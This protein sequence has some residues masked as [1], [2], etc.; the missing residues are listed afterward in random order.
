MIATGMLL[1][2]LAGCSARRDSA[3]VSVA[4]SADTP[5]AAREATALDHDARTGARRSAEA[6][7]ASR[8][9]G[10]VIRA[11]GWQAPAGWSGDIDARRP[12]SPDQAGGPATWKRASALPNA[13]RLKVGDREELPL[14]A[15]QFSVRVDAFR[16]RVMMDCLYHNDT[17]RQLEGT[18]Q[19][20]LPDGASPC[21][22][23]FGN[24][25]YSAREVAAGRAGVLERNAAGQGFSP[26]EAIEVRRGSSGWDRPIEA[27]MV[28]REKAG[29]AY[30]ET[31]HRRVDPAIMEWSGAGVFSTRVYPLLP[32]RI[33]RVVV[34]Y[35][36]DLTPAG[37]D[38]ELRLDLPAG[39]ASRIVDL[40]VAA[41][42]GMR[43]TVE[44]ETRPLAAP[45]RELFRVE[46][47][48]ADAVT[49]R[50]AGAGSVLLT[51]SDAGTGQLFAASF[52][53]ELPAGEQARPCSRAVF[54]LDTSL[55]S[56]PDRCNVHLRLLESILESN[57]ES[58]RE[59]AVVTFDISPR[60][61]R[62]EWSA[63]T[64]EGRKALLAWA[65]NLSLEGATD[66]SAA[67][68][69]AASPDWLSGA[70][71]DQERDIFL[72]GDGAA[73]WG[74]TDP[75]ALAATVRGGRG[76]A[77]FAYRTGLA[78]GDGSTLENLA[79]A[80]G[81]AVF[82]VTGEA[83]IA[84]AA[85]A[86]R[87]RSWR[88][89]EVRVEG[90]SDLLL[91]GRPES[92]F[93]GQQLLLVGRG[94]P[95]EGAVC[96]LL[97]SRG[98]EQRTVRTAIARSMESPL[99]ARTY[100]QVAVG[101]LEDLL[102]A[103]ET[104]ARHYAAHFRVTGRTCSLLMLESER[105]YQRFGL[106][107]A[108][109]AAAVRKEP[110]AAA[111][112]AAAASAQDGAGSAR[113]AFMVMVARLEAA[114]G[115]KI[116]APL[117]EM[118][119]SLP[120]EAFAVETERL[121][122]R[123]LTRARQSAGY[124]KGLAA[125]EAD[126]GAVWNEAA[127]RLETLGP[128]DALRALSSLVESRP[129]DR[130]LVQDVGMSALGWNLPGHGYHLFASLTSARP[131]EA[132][133]YRA[134]ALCLHELGRADLALAC[135]EL[136]LAGQG[137]PRLGNHQRIVALDYL[138]L[139]RAVEDGRLRPNGAWFARQRLAE[140]SREHDL[141][142]LDLLVS[143]DWNTDATDVDLRVTE[144]SGE[145]CSSSR[146]GTRGGGAMSANVTDGFGPEMYTV[147]RAPA[148]NYRISA[149]YMTGDRNRGHTATRVYATIVT[150]WGTDWERV[151]HR[152]VLLDR[153]GCLRELATVRFDGRKG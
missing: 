140:L 91:A 126:S 22:L 149:R 78:G 129:G 98:G 145:T 1:A 69:E 34:G 39:V 59:F 143:M 121:M 116:S 136:A 50:L 45:G 113:A 23:A 24:T 61:W 43:V 148:G 90:G 106:V 68:R 85:L 58:L 4:R 32:H 17:G 62:R 27:R 115:A 132:Q 5:L 142:E 9:S 75:A 93:P 138:R 80:S 3:A 127:R 139:L 108:D 35:D 70:P 20:R 96:E 33:S 144:P 36:L 41:P 117:R 31:V 42:R 152:A 7:G 119:A 74:E 146:P 25:T 101:Q 133:A 26:E 72:L 29:L 28:P 84:A 38:L 109:D 53:P 105:D 15:V 77:L 12:E 10:E 83:G 2:A 48:K 102:P 66:L 21:Y 120:N 97:L 128:A 147:K 30:R 137:D 67:L 122:P 65:G 51:G 71:A 14:R 76:G 73:T 18:F 123:R 13:T 11:G 8:G 64:P 125:S 150:G 44:P 135:Y 82:A 81:G 92:L 107:P 99:A 19:M 87:S 47:P 49:L 56:Q 130:G 55:S 134:M 131:H 79:R 124:L 104:L 151:H 88:I 103:A 118:L 52:R 112:A 141:G 40:D 46:N 110:A 60:W 94:R 100:G 57:S 153:P 86:H 37:N 95:G 111:L 54:M 6:L 89:E 16:A 63:N 114:R